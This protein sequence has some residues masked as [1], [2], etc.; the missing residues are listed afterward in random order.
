MLGRESRPR[1]RAEALEM[2]D[3]RG[4]NLAALQVTDVVDLGWRGYLGVG[5]IIIRRRREAQP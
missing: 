5:N 4:K 2:G 3:D 1:Q